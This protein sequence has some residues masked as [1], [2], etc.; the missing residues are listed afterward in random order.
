LVRFFTTLE[1]MAFIHSLF[2]FIGDTTFPG[3]GLRGTALV[4]ARFVRQG[5]TFG[6]EFAVAM[7]LNLN[8]DIFVCLG[9]LGLPGRAQHNTRT[10]RKPHPDIP[11][12][13]QNFKN[14]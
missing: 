6:T 9:L 7:A 1:K 12:R 11:R 2:T 14:S 5:Q 4:A 8:S 13:Y 3:K 10:R